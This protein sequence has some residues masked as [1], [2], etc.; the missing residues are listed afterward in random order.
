MIVTDVK[1][2]GSKDVEHFEDGLQAAKYRQAGWKMCGID[3]TLDLYKNTNNNKSSQLSG[4]EDAPP[5]AKKAIFLQRKQPSEYEHTRKFLNMEE[6][7]QFAGWAHGIQGRSVQSDSWAFCDRVRLAYGADIIVGLHSSHTT[8]ELLFARPGSVYIDINSYNFRRPGFKSLA[9]QCGIS[10]LDFLTIGKDES[11]IPNITTYT[12]ELVDDFE[13]AT[14]W[15]CAYT[16]SQC[17]EYYKNR[18][19]YVPVQHIDAYIKHALEMFDDNTQRITSSP[20]APHTVFKPDVCQQSDTDPRY[21]REG[22]PPTW[23]W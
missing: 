21:T 13:K 5:R 6:V 19:V 2:E 22:L 8:V 14:W 12:H 3:T 18:S 10:F 15:T 9:N 1:V 16:L 7:C 11:F 17:Q 20:H 23:N 4:S